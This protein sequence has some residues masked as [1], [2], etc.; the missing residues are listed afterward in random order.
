[1]FGRFALENFSLKQPLE[2]SKM[3]SEAYDAYSCTI[4]LSRMVLHTKYACYATSHLYQT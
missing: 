3:L 4:P 2:L 1:M